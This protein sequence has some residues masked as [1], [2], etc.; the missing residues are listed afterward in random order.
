MH[1]KRENFISLIVGVALVGLLVFVLYET[2]QP[3][4]NFGLIEEKPMVKVEIKDLALGT[5]EEVMAG[6]TV[7]VHYE[8]TL[9]DGTKFDSSYDHKEPIEIPVGVG[10][11][12]KGWDIGLVG[13]KVGGKRDLVIPPELGYGVRGNGPIP[14][15]TTLHF[16]VEVL[17]ITKT[18]AQAPE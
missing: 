1:T 11:V 14:P 16:I 2:K 7:R 17:G 9:L 13:M 3:H 10:A 18:A 8:G 4:E 15:N 6:D 12:I 5:G